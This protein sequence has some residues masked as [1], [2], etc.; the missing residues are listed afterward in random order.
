MDKQFVS[1]LS[2]EDLEK[3]IMKC[4][5]R[6]EEMKIS[7]NLVDENY[8]INEVAKKLGRAHD[9]IKKMVM[10]GTLKATAD[11]RRITAVSLKEYLQNDSQ[12]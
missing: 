3:L 4:L 6:F 10:D 9:T 1:L 2:E 12:N 8:S 7:K 5:V 11:G